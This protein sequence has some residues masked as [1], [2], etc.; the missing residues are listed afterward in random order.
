MLA[1]LSRWF[2]FTVIPAL[3]PIAWLASRLRARRLHVDADVLLGRGELLL[4]CSA[5]AAF[6]IGEILASGK[7]RRVRKYIVGGCCLLI[8]MVAIDDYADIG[9]LVRDGVNY[10][11]TYTAMKS[12]A[13]CVFSILCGSMSICLAGYK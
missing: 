5:F 7:K 4:A 13:L 3:V 10:D 1:S 6:G 9:L 2:C 8:L 12:V 11:V